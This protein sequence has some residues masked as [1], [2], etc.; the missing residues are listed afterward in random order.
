MDEK[1]IIMSLEKI[2]KRNS[3]TILFI[4][5]SDSIH[6]TRWI[7]QI[8]DQGWNVH[9]FPLVD[10]SVVHP[11]LTN[12]TVHQSVYTRTH[13]KK[14]Y[15]PNVKNKGSYIPFN[16]WGISA[17]F[18]LAINAFTKRYLPNYR[19]R[20]LR[21]LLKKLKPDIIH[22]L[23]FQHSGYLTIQALYHEYTPF[24]IRNVIKFAFKQF[25]ELPD[26]KKNAAK[27]DGAHFYPL[28]KKR[29]V[30]ETSKWIAT[31]WGSDIYLFGRLSSHKRK[32][33]QILENCDF[34]SCECQRDVE[35]AKSFGLKGKVLPVFPN[36]GG[37]D[38]EKISKMRQPGLPSKRRLIMLKGYQGWAY[39]AL[40]GLRGLERCADLL[41]EY[42]VAIYLANYEVRIAA[43]LFEHSTGIPVEMIPYTS[44]EKILRYHGRARISIGINISD[45]ISTSF[46]EALV[47]GSFP[48]QSWTG[49]ANEW[50]EDG[51]TGILVPP[52]DP[53]VIEKAI[54]RA[55]TDDELVNRAAEINWKTVEERLDHNSLKSKAIDMY[56]TIL[57]NSD[58]K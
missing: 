10:N 30:C 58:V 43:E 17:N 35:L 16:L 41:K 46:L 6:A 22:S 18:I 47:M 3:K 7:N 2:S 37:F 55:L 27:E 15:N 56:K 33:K 34:Y 28:S 44:H 8:S 25:Q 24:N 5:M 48:I 38:F 40:A 49:C 39:R 45:A 57:E 9:L 26:K 29:I 31:N 36:A 4:G 11:Q 13:K 52:E 51:K 23:E 42:T 12:V 14:D 20:Q 1:R 19:V 54:R 21:R 53:D 32:I 50:I